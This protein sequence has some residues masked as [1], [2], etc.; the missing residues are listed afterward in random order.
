MRRQPKFRIRFE[1]FLSGAMRMDAVSGE[2]AVF[3]G[4]TF[5]S[6]VVAGLSGF[7]FGLV[8]ASI[9]LY[10]LTPLQ[11]TTITQTLHCPSRKLAGRRRLS[12]RV[13]NP[14]PAAYAAARA[15]ASMRLRC[16]STDG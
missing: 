6:A 16:S 13:S 14:Q 10:V 15:C 7:A 8:A 9:W 5:I 2:L 3:L 11:T 1:P 4:A 12:C